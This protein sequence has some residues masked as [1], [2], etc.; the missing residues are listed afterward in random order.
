MKQSNRSAVGVGV[1]LS[2][3]L[4]VSGTALAKDTAQMTANL[5]PQVKEITGKS[6]IELDE[7][8]YPHFKSF[9]AGTQ[10]ECEEYL[11]AKHEGKVENGTATDGLSL[12]PIHLKSKFSGKAAQESEADF[13][14]VEEFKYKLAIPKEYRK[15]AKVIVTWTMEVFGNSPA[16]MEIENKLCEGAWYGTSIQAFPEGYSVISRCIVNS[17]MK[18]P[19]GEAKISMPPGEERTHVSTPPPPPSPPCEPVMTGSALIMPDDYNG[20][21]PASLIIEIYWKND[22]PLTVFSPANS[23]QMTITLM[24]LDREL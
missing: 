20:E 7:A 15:T 5:T 3:W 13:V 17:D 18:N 24:P 22:S 8:R 23:R 21:L 19:K 1:F 10:P 6:R 9:E 4:L 2:L 12:A 16:A 14:P 11:A